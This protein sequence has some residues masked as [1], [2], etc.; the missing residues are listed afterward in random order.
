MFKILVAIPL[1]LFFSKLGGEMD[2]NEIPTKAQDISPLLI[3]EKVPALNLVST[4]NKIVSFAEVLKQKP[5]VVLFYRGGWCPYCNAHLSRVAKVEQE[6]LDLGYQVIGISPDSPKHLMET[7]NKDSLGYQLFSD[8][9]GE[10]MKAMG[11]AFQ[12]P[13]KKKAKLDRYSE[14][15]NSGLLPV[16]SLFVVDRDGTILFEYISPNYKNR[17]SAPMLLGILKELKKKG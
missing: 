16:P 15:E 4:D 11:I 10:L 9:N 2:H 13:E 5:A 12:A 3:S 1:V 17:I 6:I 7:S 8:G 14:G